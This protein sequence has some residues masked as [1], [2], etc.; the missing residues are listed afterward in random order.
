MWEQVLLRFVMLTFGMFGEL[1]A[2]VFGE[3]WIVLCYL[4][5]VNP[6]DA[7]KRAGSVLSTVVSNVR[8]ASASGAGENGS[9]HT[10]FKWK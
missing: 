1:W 7:L 9:G 10:I 2:V 8:G 6:W 5:Q 3:V 4:M